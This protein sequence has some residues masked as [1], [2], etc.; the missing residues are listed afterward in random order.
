MRDDFNCDNSD[1]YYVYG[2]EHDDIPYYIG[3]SRLPVQK[4]KRGLIA[5][6][7]HQGNQKAQ[8]ITRNFTAR[9]IYPQIIIY[10]Q[11]ISEERALAIQDLYVHT[12]ANTVTNEGRL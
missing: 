7:G 10:E 4:T 6:R 1:S 9:G 3:I 2:I 8:E 11:G 5:W 12:H